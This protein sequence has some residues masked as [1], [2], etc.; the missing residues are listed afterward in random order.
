MPDEFG[1]I[2]KLFAPLAASFPGALGLRDDAALIDGPAGSL[3]AV[4]TDALVAGVHFLADDPPDLVARKVIRVNLSDLAAMGA[5][6]VA[7]LLAACFPVGVGDGWLERFAIGLKGD[8]E[9]FSIAL[10]GG[11]TVSTPGPICL[12]L[13]AFGWGD[14]AHSPHRS[15][16][17]A[18]D[19]IWV[20]GT[21]GDGGAGLQAARG[22]VNSDFLKTRYELP[23]PRVGLGEWLRFG[24]RRG[25]VCGLA[26]AVG[27]GAS[28]GPAQHHCR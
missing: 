6:P 19:D 12:G 23:T 11:D 22:A 10:I 9:T 14:P 7:I 2:A 18:G 3:W 8:C 1:L 16:A 13:T 15:G 26:V 24:L 21:I 20:S 25:A 4:T 5:R 17:Q 27:D 28:G